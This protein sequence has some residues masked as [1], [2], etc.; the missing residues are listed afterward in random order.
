MGIFIVSCDVDFVRLCRDKRLTLGLFQS[1]G[2]DYTKVYS[3]GDIVFPEFCKPFDGSD[4][5]ETK[6]VSTLK[7]ISLSDIKI[8]IK[9]LSNILMVFL[10]IYL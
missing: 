6:L 2:M 9:G 1:S 3:K 4:S 8:Q 10:R 5:I 7:E